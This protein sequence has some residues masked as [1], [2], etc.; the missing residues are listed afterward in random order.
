MS[1]DAVKA[2]GDEEAESHGG[3]VED[4]LGH[5]ESHGKEHVGRR[6]K[7]NDHDAI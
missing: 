5:H 7:R 3:E 4:A 2:D 1:F 6:Q